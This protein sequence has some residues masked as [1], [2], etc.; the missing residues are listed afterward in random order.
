MSTALSPFLPGTK[1]QYAL[2]S[3]SLGAAK[4]CLRYYHYSIIE[5]WRKKD[6]SVHLRFGGE[7]AKWVEFYWKCRFAN[8]DD[9]EAALDETVGW[10]LYSILDWNPDHPKKNRE[11]LV[12]SVIWYLDAYKNDPAKPIILA[13]G[14]P[15]VEL[16]FKIELPWEAAPGQPYIY[17]GHMDRIADYAGDNFVVDEKTTAGGIGAYFFNDFNPST[18]MTGYTFAGKVIFGIPIAGVI[19]DAIKVVTGF[20]EFARGFTMRTEGQLAEWLED[21]KHWTE[22]I[23]FA[24]ERDYFPQNDQSC[25]QYGGCV[26][27]EVCSQD[28]MVRKEFLETY[29]E[30]N[31]WNPL[32]KR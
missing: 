14:Q 11:T 24:V 12:R 7:L 22:I 18:Q 27:R 2:D 13:N 17:C 32:E 23:K 5:G 19:I 28:P 25:H 6:E 9:H 8:G 29:F 26:F 31:R 21:T 20:T 15:A 1:L 3:T 10:M 16:S 30:V 4:K